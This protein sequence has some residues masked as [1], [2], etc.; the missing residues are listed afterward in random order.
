MRW[1]LLSLLVLHGLIHLMGFAK[2][3]DL[4]EL[5][6]LTRP[7]SP[8]MGVVWLLACLGFLAS[9]VFL[10]TAPRLWWLVAFASVVLSQV[11][12][13]SAWSDASFGTLANLLILAAVAYG[14]ASQGPWS[15]R[16]RYRDA[17]EERLARLEAEAVAETVSEAELARLPE[18]VRRYLRRSGAV[19]R[20]RP[21]HFRADLR[22]R[23]RGGPDEPWMEFT[24]E[25]HNFLDEPA[26]FFLMDAR[27]GGLPV[28]VFHAYRSGT[29]TMRVRLLSLFPMVDARGPEMDR[30][31]TVTVLNDL[32]LF[33]PG[34]LVDPS[35]E[36]EPV[37]DSTARAHYAVGGQAIR[38][39][40]RF[41]ASG[42]LVDFVSDDRMAASPDGTSFRPMRWSTPVEGYRDLDGARAP[43]RGVGVWHPDEGQPW[44]YLEAEWGAVEVDGGR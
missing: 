37:D 20:P 30:A 39:T 27:R 5:E 15:F 38:A 35:I 16:A 10:L 41:D 13:V 17:V 29:A 3:F 7:V 2:A 33:A 19:G 36:W 44:P 24:A 42:D 31:E 9:A 23:I 32:A 34:G 21:R 28:D 11:A 26:R 12:I 14:F 8:G 40:L 25:Q 4:A 43:A 22:G 6:E 1:L 18:P